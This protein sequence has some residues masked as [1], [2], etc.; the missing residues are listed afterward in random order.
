MVENK[1]DLQDFSTK[2]GD[3]VA[4]VGFLV[5]EAFGA[6]NV[7]LKVASEAKK[8]SDKELEKLLKPL[9]DKINEIQVRYTFQH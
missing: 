3:D 9:S 8:P 4:K 1:F 2:I 7:I 5:K 6:Q